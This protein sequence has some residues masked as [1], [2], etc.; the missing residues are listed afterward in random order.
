MVFF[1]FILF[2]GLCLNI[3]SNICQA[4][5]KKIFLTTKFNEVNIRNG[6]GLNHLRIYKILKKGYP[7]RVLDE[8]E[9]WRKIIDV[10][11]VAGWVSNSQL[12][13]KEYVIVK[14]IEEIIYK[15][16]TKKSKRIAIIRKNFV[17]KVKKCG[18]SWCS[19]REGKIKGWI[20]KDSLWGH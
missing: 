12:S 20:K 9:N 1:R 19:I 7:L 13:K 6:P 11:G 18:K 14:E 17:V 16:P 15:F 5:K 3:P 8:F 10:N 2:F 4:E